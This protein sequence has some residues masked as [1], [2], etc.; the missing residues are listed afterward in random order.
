[1]LMGDNIKNQEHLPLYGVG[2]Y[3]VAPMII[4][5]VLGLILSYYN[6]IPVYKFDSLYWLFI[7]LAVVLILDGAFLWLAAVKL[8][9]ITDKIENNQLITYGVYALV[10]HPIYSAW[11]QLATALILLSQNV[12]LLILPVIFWA[13]LS[14]AMKKT[15]EKWLLDKF[16]NE[17]AN[18]C[19]ATNRFIPFRKSI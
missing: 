8:S 3:L 9:N 2:P 18:Y 17:Y 7:G 19:K 4:V 16:G 10:R 5:S 6:L 1:M 13:L 15:E 12:Y 11:L 14:L